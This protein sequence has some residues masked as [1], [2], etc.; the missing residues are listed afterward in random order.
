VAD[1]EGVHLIRKLE[2][3]APLLPRDEDALS[4]LAARRT[5]GCAAGEDV[6]SEGDEPKTIYLVLEGW[7]CRYKTLEDGRRQLLSLFIPGD[8]C[9]LH[10][11]I[12]SR[13]DHSI[14]AITPL[15]IARISP[16]ELEAVGDAH[17]RVMRA[18]WWESLVSAAIQREWLVS[19][20]QRSALESLAHLLC[21][22]FMRLRLVGLAERDGCAFPLTQA[23]I[24]SALGLTQPHVSRVVREL[25]DSGVAT[26][27][28]RRLIVHD[29]KALQQ[30]AGFNPNYLHYR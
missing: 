25:N 2:A 10:V 26:L 16:A 17:P 30:L 9:D 29:Q 24:A 4:A 23:N 3:F 8:L 14:A 12:L 1:A 13:M 22:T 28:R 27:S 15:R 20:G 21:E 18:L 5:S 19:A 7:A 6:I 11:Y